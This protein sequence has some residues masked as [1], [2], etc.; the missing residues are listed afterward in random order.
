MIEIKASIGQILNGL[1]AAHALRDLLI[2]VSMPA[3][4]HLA[5]TFLLSRTQRWRYQRRIRA[6]AHELKVYLSGPYTVD[7]RAERAVTWR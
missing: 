2:D 3:H 7:V 6:F 1:L 5:V 4:N